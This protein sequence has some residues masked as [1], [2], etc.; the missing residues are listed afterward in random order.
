MSFLSPPRPPAGL[1]QRFRTLAHLPRLL[2][3]LWRTSPALAASAILLRMLRALQ[4]P[5]VLFVG[6]LIV[7]E[8]VRLNGQAAPGPAF[9]DWLASGHLHPLASLI[10]LELLIVVGAALS[11]RLGTLG[12]TLLA[13]RHANGQGAA[14]IRQAAAL[15]LA[16]I[17]TAQGQD[18]LTR[19]RVQ[20]L[21]GSPLLGS[22]LMQAQNAVTLLA[23]LA[24]ILV[25]APALVLLLVFA[26][27]PT[28]A[29]EAHF[30]AKA[31]ALS[32][33]QTPQ[34]RQLEY[35][36][37][38]G[39]SGET[40]KEVKLFGLGDH[41]AR[42]FA[43]ISARLYA[44]T[45]AL[46]VRR[47]LW[48]SLLGA[49]GSVAY[50]A[51]YAVIAWKA[52][53]GTITIGDLTFLAG[54]LLR[55]NG[56]LEGLV[57]GLT[58]L[59]S[60]A[61]FLDDFYAFMDRRPGLPTPASPRSFP[62]PVTQGVVFE[63]VGFRY[64]GKQDWALRHL[65]FTLPA[66][67]TL[68]LVGENGAGKTTIVKLLTRLYDPTEGR[69]LIDGVDLRDLDPEVLRDHVGAIFQDF[70]RYNMTAAE[71]IGIGRVAAMANHPRIVEAARRSLAD[72]FIAAMPSG[73]DQMLGRSFSQGFDLSGGE[74]QKVAI[75]RAYFRD[76]EIL[77]LDEPTAA[78]DA[79]AE[80]ELFERFRN[81][82]RS[83][84]VLLI[85]HRFS[86]VRMADR[87]LVL[88]HGTILE[89][90]SH[91]ELMALSGRYAELFTLQAA[92]FR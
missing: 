43:V 32:V 24:G 74:W 64:P 26:L 59:A 41:L 58:Q 63:N 92:G 62:S 8:I 7:D 89:S 83:R 35:V 40:A 25:Y 71:N 55:L 84:T 10:A 44:A 39:S 1:R 34:R 69:I 22:V 57:L 48:S 51:A 49:V 18:R 37:Q 28:L 52:A 85:S 82:S 79:R 14:L 3:S 66:G 27:V 13:E 53:S 12:E 4:P 60:Q 47:A 88:E 87:I 5:L 45:R 67:E 23:L 54:S 17:E 50:Y 76:A 70:V 30:N 15:D 72:P 42:R 73:Y 86:T 65:D 2:G 90:G 68:A 11:T 46:A 81:L 33:S 80:V 6:K 61:Q 16:E 77:V 29:T 9:G 31:Y 78:L 75:A 21:S 91:D 56:L 38:I 36:R 19:A 20:T